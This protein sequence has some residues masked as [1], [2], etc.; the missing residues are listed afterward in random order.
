MWY[1]LKNSKGTKIPVKSTING[2]VLTMNHTLLVKNTKY[3]IIL[4]TVS[5]M[6]LTGNKQ[7]LYTL[8]LIPE[9]ILYLG[10]FQTTFFK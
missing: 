8:Q 7:A 3:T 2:N 1:E 10:L 6:D 5:V 9:K 4:H